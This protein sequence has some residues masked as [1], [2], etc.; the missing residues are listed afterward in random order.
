MSDK[1]T[2]HDASMSEKLSY[3]D[4]EIFGDAIGT[5][6]REANEDEWAEI[7]CIVDDTTKYTDKE[8]AEHPL[9]AWAKLHLQEEPEFF[10]E[11]V[12]WKHPRYKADTICIRF[13]SIEDNPFRD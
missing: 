5:E 1:E 13:R 3:V 10:F 12:M 11:K 2:L 8:S 7:V 6:V 4:N 9:E